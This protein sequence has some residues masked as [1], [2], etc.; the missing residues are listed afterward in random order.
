MAKFDFAENAALVANLT[1]TKYLA[2]C[3][4]APT[5]SQTGST[6]P[7]LSGNGYARQAVTFTIT[8]SSATNAAQ[9]TYTASGGNWVQATHVAVCDSL[10]G[11]NAR[12]YAALTNP[13]TLSN[14]EAGTVPA[15]GVVISED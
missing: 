5:D 8:G 15:G 12:Y 2:L 14:G 13:I 11:G 7:E 3:S 4:A 6:I 1:G 9:A 10:T